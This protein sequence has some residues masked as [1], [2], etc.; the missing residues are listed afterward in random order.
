MEWLLHIN[1]RWQKTQMMNAL[2]TIRFETS[3]FPVV[4]RQAGVLCNREI[5]IWLS[6]N[7]KAQFQEVLAIYERICS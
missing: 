3:K 2:M 4:M 1:I 7:R 6:R 5:D